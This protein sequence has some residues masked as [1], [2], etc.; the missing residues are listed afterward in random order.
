MMS[1][2]Q[3]VQS[4]QP[5]EPTLLN[6]RMN[7][8]GLDVGAWLRFEPTMVA[9][10]RR[11]C[12]ACRETVRC[13]LDLAAHADDPAWRDWKEYCPNAAKLNML[14]ALQFY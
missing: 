10:L 4:D 2:L 3:A 12:S 11:A 8:L 9:E 1:L 5:A 14:V 7:A 6:E 13:Q